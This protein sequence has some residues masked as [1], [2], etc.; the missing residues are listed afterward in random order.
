MRRGA[1]HPKVFRDHSASESGVQITLSQRDRPGR[2][3]LHH[4]RWT[5]CRSSGPGTSSRPVASHGVV[6]PHVFHAHRYRIQPDVSPAL[7]GS[8][9]PDGLLGCPS[10]HQ[11]RASQERQRK[12]LTT[13]RVSCSAALTLHSLRSPRAP[14]CVAPASFPGDR[15]GA[16][17]PPRHRHRSQS[18]APTTGSVIDATAP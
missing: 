2:V 12:P 8:H 11:A 14:S 7:P 17:R 6:S 18:C 3:V 10:R 1:Q 9:R 16:P 4:Q 13:C 15:S 5:S